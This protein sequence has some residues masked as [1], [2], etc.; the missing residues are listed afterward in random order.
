MSQGI[1]IQYSLR[2]LGTSTVEETIQLRLKDNAV[3]C[4]LLNPVALLSH[5]CLIITLIIHSHID[6]DVL[7]G[8]HHRGK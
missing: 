5:F 1:A 7:S 6:S 2:S 8:I 4:C 3:S